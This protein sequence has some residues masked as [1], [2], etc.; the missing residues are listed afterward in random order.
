MK[1]VHIGIVLAAG[2]ALLTL[3]IASDANARGGLATRGASAPRGLHYVVHPRNL[4][5][6]HHAGQ[7]GRRFNAWPF[8]GTGYSW[9]AYGGL[10]AVP[11]YTAGDGN[12]AVFPERVVFVPVPPSAITCKHSV[13]TLTVRAEAGGTRD[14]TVFRC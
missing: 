7:F 1:V 10:Y 13:E 11:P 14:I 6:R 4:L 8:Y 12:T 9:P 3:T 5:E 2:L